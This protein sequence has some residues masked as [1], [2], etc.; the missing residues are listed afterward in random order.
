MKQPRR[1][2]VLPINQESLTKLQERFGSWRKTKAYPSAPIPHQLWNEAV[3]MACTNG[4]A[5]VSQAL[6]L[7]YNGLKRRM[8]DNQ[9]RSTETK[10]ETAFVRVEMNNPQPSA[11]CVVELTDP[12][13]AKMTIRLGA[14]QAAIL[15]G[16]VEVFGRRGR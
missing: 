4:V 15:P 9:P 10:S 7:D 11:G 2:S 1:K 13:G 3:Q 14:Q 16:L 8:S 12:T 5:H 6:G